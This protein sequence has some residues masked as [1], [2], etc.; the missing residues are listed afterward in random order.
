M[1]KQGDA[2]HR[3]NQILRL[4]VEDLNNLGFGVAHADGKTVF[5]AD[6]VDGDEIDAR[7]INV[8]KNYSVARV[9]TLHTPSPHR[10][11]SFCSVRGCGGCAYRAVTYAHELTRKE[12]NVRFAFRKAGL[13]DARIMPVTST[14]VTHGYRNK[15][16]Y[17]VAPDKK[18]MC[19][20]GFY[21]PKSHRLCDAAD[22]PLQNAAFPPIVKTVLAFCNENG[23]APY[24]EE[25]HSGLLR[26]IY[27]RASVSGDVLLTLV[28]THPDF[29]E[30]KALLSLLNEKHPEIKGVYLNINPEKT[31]VICTNDYRHLRGDTHL[32]D[33]LCG[34]RLAISPASFY[35]VNHDAAELLYSKAAALA[36]F[37]GSESILDL[38]SGVGSIGLSM[39]KH[40]GEVIGVEIVSSATEC[41]KENAKING[42]QNAL[43]LCADAGEGEA[44]LRAVRERKG[45]SY[46]PDAVI[47]DPP[48]AGCAR[49]LLYTL[50]REENV[51]KI[52]YISCN[53]DTLARDA[54]ILTDEGYTMS[55]IYPFDLFPRTGHVESVVCFTRD[56]N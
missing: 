9:E 5:I 37:K 25:T 45:K 40:V 4:K 56:S 50:A 42:I 31:N 41:A 47:L 7:I 1:K 29:K 16:Q 8:Q 3:K 53:P 46:R 15:A 34:V 2:M 10:E 35:Q 51:P 36:D 28:V 17:A 30:Q 27:L 22:C 55:A 38:Y 20:A 49:E 19:A 23:I 11:N 44:L 18:G 52:V 26:H 14:G 12:N 13:A 6:A 39:A 33:T 48:R 24:C 54:K 43:F 32:Y 21:A